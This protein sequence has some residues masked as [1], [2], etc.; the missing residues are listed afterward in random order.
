MPQA[1]SNQEREAAGIHHRA[2]GTGDFQEKT[3]VT[4]RILKKVWAK[5]HAWLLRHIKKPTQLKRSILDSVHSYVF[6]ARY[7]GYGNYSH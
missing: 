4:G 1:S 2:K 3:T 7:V 6:L 5:A